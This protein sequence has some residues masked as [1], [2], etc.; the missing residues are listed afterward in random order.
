MVQLSEIKPPD[1]S[2]IA[3][4]LKS[5]NLSLPTPSLAL[6]TDLANIEFGALTS[7][8]D[9]FSGLAQNLPTSLDDLLGDLLNELKGLSAGSLDIGDLLGGLTEPFSQAETILGEFGTTLHTLTTD[10]VPM[11]LNLEQ[12]PANLDSLAQLLPISTLATPL[13]AQLPNLL[14]PQL[15]QVQGARSQ[16]QVILK[17]SPLAAYQAMLEAIASLPLDPGL[18]VAQL[19]ILDDQQTAQ[20]KAQL[21]E[22]QQGLEQVTD[23]LNTCQQGLQAMPTALTDSL[24]QALNLLSPQQLAQQSSFLTGALNS[25]TQLDTVDLSGLI[26]NLKTVLEPLQTW[27]D[28]GVATATQGVNTAVTTV[29]NAIATADQALVKVSALVTHVI[30]QLV[31]FI[32]TV[33]LTGLIN[34]AKEIFQGL[35]LKLNGVLNQVGGVIEQIYGFVRRMVDQVKALGA[36]LP[37]LAE[38]FRQ[39][40]GQLTAFLDNPQVK[41]A[42]QQAKQG[43]NSVVEKLDVVSLEPVFDQVLLQAETVKTSLQAIDLSQLNQML[44]SALSAALDLVKQAI[45]PPSKVTDLVNEQYKTL[46]SDPILGG[47]IQPVKDQIDETID[48]V[49][50]LEPGTLIGNLLTPLYEQALASVKHFV[51]PDQIATLLQPLTDFQTQLLEEIDAVVNPSNLLAPLM[52]FYEQIMGFVQSLQPDT[53]LAPL[54]ALLNQAT[55]PLESLGLEQWVTTITGSIRSVTGLI[56]NFKID[57]PLEKLFD[58]GIEPLVQPWIGQLQALVNQLDVSKLQTLLQPLRTVAQTLVE[59]TRLD[60][61]SALAIVQQV[62]QWVAEVTQF[63]ARYS[64]E[65][66]RWVQLWQ[67]SCDR[68]KQFTPSSALRPHFDALVQQLQR[69]NPIALLASLTQVISRL[70]DSA[71]ALLETLT[72]LWQSLHNR[73]QRGKAT[74]DSLLDQTGDGLKSYLQAALDAL[75]DV[76]LKPL[77]AKLNQPLRQFKSIMPWVKKLQAALPVFDL[78]PQSIQTIGDAIVGVKNKIRGLNFNFLLAPLARVK[79]EIEKPLSALNPEPI[80]IVPFTQIYNKVLKMLQNLNPVQLFATPRGTLTLKA[81][82]ATAPIILPLGTQLAAT[83]PLGHEV[84]FETLLETTIPAGGQIEVPIRA[85]V[86]GRA[87]DIVGIADVTW[88]VAEHTELQAMHQQPILSLI[89]LVQEEMLGILQVFDPVKLIAE[90]LNEQYAKIMQLF[91]ELGLATLLDALFQKIESLDRDIQTG[92]GKVGIAFNSLVAAMPL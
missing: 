74:I 51:D 19:P 13:T 71:T 67:G 81:E 12:Q 75:V 27:V 38:Q 5:L 23:G 55:Q 62:Q 91:D 72:T 58:Q 69:L 11:L 70:S 64:Q 41:N 73:L 24:D 28:K 84:W 78:I 57:A 4:Q 34:Q 43:I 63:A 68:I 92:L 76:A 45:D 10:L 9:R 32:Q 65:M 89:T 40:L 16:L 7:V 79:A 86:S 18:T 25:L 80:L 42:V 2:A 6:P 52:G 56:S 1:F 90:P 49:H 50:Q 44:K 66:S 85:M 61:P 82:A 36:Q 87:S 77:I 39:L 21:D 20:F 30:D 47:I 17:Q 48:L 54:N 31:E 59:Q 37:P 14:A 33:D 88:R 3:T 83:T 53:L 46:I 8:V 60:S 26:D 35:M 15:Q 29:E 22:L